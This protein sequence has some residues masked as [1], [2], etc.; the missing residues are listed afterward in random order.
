MGWT[1]LLTAYGRAQEAL[2]AEPRFA[3]ACA[4][5]F[6]AAVAG[7]RPAGGDPLPRLGPARDDGSSVLWESFRFCFT[8]RTLFYDRHVLR[9][10]AAGC[11]QVVVLGAGLDCRAFRLGLPADVTVFEV[12]RAAVLD[13]KHEVLAKNGRV[14]TCRRVALAA[15][16]TG[17]LSGPLAAAGLDPAKP[18]L[19]VVEGLL[20]Y[21]TADVADRVLTEVT[22][23]SAPGSLIV[24]EYFVR[25]WENED[26]GYDALDEQE[27]AAWHLL[28]GA[29]E[30]GP[31]DHKP[32]DWL[33]SHHWTPDEVTTVAEEAREEGRAIPD[34]FGRPGANDLWL[35][36][37]TRVA[38]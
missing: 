7:A 25:S 21:F 28:V 14:P 10:V 37:G 6:V 26:V 23:L 2:E 33:A 22:S 20:M 30:Y 8:Q 16:V 36:T 38:D 11:R 24:S 13:F 1:A 31:M 4:A 9:A 15:D 27:K 5:D 35:F 32:G 34:V 3:D 17:G 18:V 29:F 12:D 19:W